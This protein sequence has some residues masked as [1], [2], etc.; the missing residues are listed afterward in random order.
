MLKVLQSFLFQANTWHNTNRLVVN[1]SKSSFMLLG[2][3]K[4]SDYLQDTI[5]NNVKLEHTSTRLLGLHIQTGLAWKSTLPV[6]L[7]VCPLKLVSFSD[8]ANSKN[9][10]LSANYILQLMSLIWTT[11]LLLY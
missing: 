3:T 10:I 2:N 9:W 6:L 5:L 4:N 8:L 11:V 1:A 7:R